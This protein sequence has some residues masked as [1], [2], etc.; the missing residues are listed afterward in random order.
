MKKKV[1]IILAAIALSVNYGKAADGELT[2]KLNLKYPINVSFVYNCLENT[3][4]ERSFSDGKKTKFERISDLYFTHRLRDFPYEGGFI[5]LSVST[6]SLKH[7]LINDKGK[8]TFNSM[9]GN[10]IEGWNEDAEQYSIP[11]SRTYKFVINPY[12]EFTD[13]K[14]DKL[15][16]ERKD[17]E[18]NKDRME[19]SSAI[20]WTNALSNERL[21]HLTDPKKIEFLGG[22]LKKD[23][24]WLSPIEFQFGG[25]TFY[26][27][28]QVKFLGERGGYLFL[29]SK[30]NAKKFVKT[31]TILY[32]LRKEPVSA[33]S[34]NANC[35]FSLTMNSRGNVEDATLEVKGNIWYKG[36]K[37]SVFADVIE[38]KFV[39]KRQSQ[40]NY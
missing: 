30:F 7:T 38:S 35:T 37:G 34:A 10:P 26:D 29:E 31:P 20:M 40:W 21:Y 15:N 12:F 14:G 13:I 27:T 11:M 4:V 24:T 16:N 39:W 28:V 19:E 1:L 22:N 6:D 17:L 2:Y 18:S 33:D 23:T 9:S 25:L 5:D 8:H 36:N 3:K 32:G